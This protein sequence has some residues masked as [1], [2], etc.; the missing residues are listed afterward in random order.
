[1]LFYVIP[2]KVRRGGSF[3]QVSATADLHGSD[4]ILSFLREHQYCAV[5]QFVQ[6]SL[7]RDYGQPL[8]NGC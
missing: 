6:N 8:I 5:F 1:M 2:A 3:Q 4:G 7:K